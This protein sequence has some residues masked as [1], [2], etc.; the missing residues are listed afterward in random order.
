MTDM[1]GR[2]QLAS[3]VRKVAESPLFTGWRWTVCLGVNIAIAAA[4]G[5]YLAWAGIEMTDLTYF[6]NLEQSRY[7][8]KKEMHAKL[9]VERDSL[10][11]PAEL[12]AK[13]Q[14]FGMKESAPGQI[15]RLDPVQPGVAGRK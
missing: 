6:I 14:K 1:T 4:T 10:L 11:S 15:R 7:N 8:D 3:R 5:V 12:R 9:Q 2:E 13:A